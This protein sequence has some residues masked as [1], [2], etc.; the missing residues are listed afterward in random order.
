MRV[1]RE[2][3][4]VEL[5]MTAKQWAKLE[6]EAALCG[7]T[8]RKLVVEVLEVWSVDKPDP[9]TAGDSGG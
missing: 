8:L 3:K 4:T 5:T 6:H 7:L 1:K 9:P 2:R